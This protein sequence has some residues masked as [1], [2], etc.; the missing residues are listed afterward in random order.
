MDDVVGILLKFIFNRSF[1]LFQVM[2]VDFGVLG[3]VIHIACLFSSS[4]PL[5]SSLKYSVHCK[6]QNRHSVV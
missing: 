3:S 6:Y 2:Q 5:P 4:L 1:S